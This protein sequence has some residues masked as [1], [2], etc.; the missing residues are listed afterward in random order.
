MITVVYPGTFDPITYGHLDILR[1]AV[2]VFQHVI[3]ATTDVPQKECLFALEERLNQLRQATEG[4]A[5]V[6]V[7]SFNGML[8]DF[9][10]SVG[11]SVIVRGLRETTDFEYEFQMALMNKRVSPNVETIFLVTS[12]DYLYLSSSLVTEMAC[13]GGDISAFVPPFVQDAIIRKLGKG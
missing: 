13:R 5:G 2:A 4:M 10:H 11:A 8:V 12:L 7:R 6:E 3:V 9:V 1:R